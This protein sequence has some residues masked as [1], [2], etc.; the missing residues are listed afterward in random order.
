MSDQFRLPTGVS[1]GRRHRTTTVR[2]ETNVANGNYGSLV[3]PAAGATLMTTLSAVTGH[4]ITSSVCG[5]GQ[6]TEA[7]KMVPTSST[8]GVPAVK[9]PFIL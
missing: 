1:L 3:D 5:V 4:T 2:T 8:S 7:Y 9:V 6:S